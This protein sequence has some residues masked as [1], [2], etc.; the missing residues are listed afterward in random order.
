VCEP[1]ELTVGRTMAKTIDVPGLGRLTEEV[2][3]EWVAASRPVPALGGHKCSFV[4]QGLDGGPRDEDYFQA[5][6]Q[7]LAAGESLLADATPH[8]HRYCRD[9][10]KLW[11][12]KAP[13]L[14][15][16][17]PAD[18]WRYVQFGFEAMLSRNRGKGRDVFVSLECNCDW[19]PEHGLQLVF[20]NG[21]TISKV[22]PFDGHLTNESAYADPRLRG[23]VY[24][25]IGR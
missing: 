13:A 20:K 22:G 25:A 14:E 19:E 8:V 5:A 24:K 15:I 18:V 6:R 3:A 16:T 17:K 1:F 10:L 2:D 11:G 7:L 12:D 9:M 21:Q 23:V 4:F